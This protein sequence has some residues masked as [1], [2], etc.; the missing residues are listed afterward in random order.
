MKVNENSIPQWLLEIISPDE[1]YRRLNSSTTEHKEIEIE[2]YN[3][4]YRLIFKVI[5]ESWN[6]ISIYKINPQ[7]IW[8]RID[9]GDEE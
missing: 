7:G 2:Y 1:L 8:Y 6:L 4:K 5:N 9:K 3:E